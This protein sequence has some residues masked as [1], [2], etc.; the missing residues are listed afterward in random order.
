MAAGGKLE[1]MLIL[2]FQDSKKAE[3][4]GKAEADGYLEVLINPETYTH[5]YK[6]KYAESGQGQG[7]SGQELKYEKTEPEEMTFEFLFDNTGIIDGQ[8]RE[9]IA[10]EL[11]AFKALLIE[12]KGEAHQPNIIKL[13]WG[14][15][16]VFKGR[17]MELSIAYKLFTPNGHPIRAVAK[18]KLKS[19]VEEEMRTRE[20]K[21]SSPDLTHT[22]RVKAGDTLPLLCHRIY[23]DARYY[24]Q[25]AAAN[26]L[27]NF[28]RLEPGTE[29]VFPP[30]V[31]GSA[32]GVASITKTSN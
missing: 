28:R 8:P 24:L 13:A 22:R 17:V 26:G 2:G 6:L 16:P 4:G 19:T 7:T 10:D 29:L 11:A 3:T 20:E 9:S 25:V 27:G 23:G 31:G 1:K 14:G 32:L 15:N 12:Y 30:V 5:E 21:R 18:V